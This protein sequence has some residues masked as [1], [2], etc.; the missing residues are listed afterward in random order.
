M[1]APADRGL[2]LAGVC[3][4]PRENRAVTSW[5]RPGETAGEI[6]DGI[7]GTFALIPH[8]HRPHRPRQRPRAL[9]HPSSS[10]SPRSSSPTTAYL[11]VPTLVSGLPEESLDGFAAAISA[12]YARQATSLISLNSPSGSA[13]KSPTSPPTLQRSPGPI[14]PLMTSS[15]SLPPMPSPST[16]GASSPALPP[17]AFTSLPPSSLPTVLSDEAALILDI[18]P[19][20]SYSQARVP[21]ALSLSVPSTLLKRPNFSL[22]RLAEMLPTSAARDRFARWPHASRILVYDADSA[23]LPPTSNLLGLMRKFR[24]EGFPEAREI[25]WLRSGFHAVWR[26]HPSLVEHGPPPDVLDEDDAIGEPEADGDP[27]PLGVAPRVLRAKHLPK[28]AFTAASTIPFKPRVSGIY[29]SQSAFTTSRIPRLASYGDGYV[30]EKG[31]SP[32][33]ETPFSVAE[34]GSASLVSPS[35]SPCLPPSLTSFLRLRF[36]IVEYTST[37]GRFL[38]AS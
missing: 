17:T 29:N 1:Q 9:P 26:E 20:N 31:F 24:C 13:P 15:L 21:N 34:S 37:P 7:S 35:P 36:Q 5:A 10:S 22:A 16:L 4:A 28:A 25:A 27:A 33:R 38:V 12:R 14:P 8:H 30:C 6:A 3:G 2:S 11:N 32:F 18:R 19:H 23:S